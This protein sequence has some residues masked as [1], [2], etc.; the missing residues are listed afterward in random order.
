MRA[1]ARGRASGRQRA[2]Q[3]DALLRLLIGDLEATAGQVTRNGKLR[4][5]YFAQHHVDALTMDATPVEFLRNKWPG[6]DIEEYR[7]QLGAFG[8]TGDTALQRISTLSGGQ[9]S[10]LAFAA[11]AMTQPHLLALDEVG[12]RGAETGRA[13]ATDSPRPTARC[14]ADQP[15][16]H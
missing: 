16:G 15:L 8:V 6:R 11:L 14:T 9:K 10:R 12:G 13:L 2:G 7:R 5:G 4:I 3:D 1:R